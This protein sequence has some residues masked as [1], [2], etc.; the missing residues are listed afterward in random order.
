MPPQRRI[1]WLEM[2]ALP[3]SIRQGETPQDGPEETAQ[4]RS[5]K[6]RLKF[7]FGLVSDYSLLAYCGSTGFFSGNEF[8]L[9]VDTF[10]PVDRRH[11]F[12][13]LVCTAMLDYCIEHG[14]APVWETPETNIGSQRVAEKLGFTKQEIYPVFSFEL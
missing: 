7:G 6:Q 10:D 1:E 5:V 3:H 12:A 8:M 11:G 14:Y 13:M 2:P 9:E 4:L